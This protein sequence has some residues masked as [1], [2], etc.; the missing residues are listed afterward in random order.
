MFI[1][2]NICNPE[3]RTGWI[4]VIAGCMFSGKTEE[5]IRRLN[6]SA[7]ARQKVA[8]FKP[9]VDNRYHAD[10]VVSHDRR[11]IE[12][13]AVA[14]ARDIPPLVEGIEVVGIDE[15]QFFN[16]SI[17][18]VANELANSGKRVVI[19]GLDMDYTGK[20]FGPM[21]YLLAIAEFVTK[22]NAICARTGEIAS[23][24]FRHP[25][26]DTAQ[27]LLGEKDVYEARGR[28]AFYEG[29]ESRDTYAAAP[30]KKAAIKGKKA[31]KAK[32]R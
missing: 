26:E 12:S 30:K 9:K 22:V 2:R 32:K 14:S 27:V 15:A 23:Y 4:E 20:P 6:R 5:L 21:P 17:I 28:R 3:A 31:A 13:V 19:A 10:N 11:V 8:I 29:M 1:E 25:G 24:T 16:E 18:D 7:I